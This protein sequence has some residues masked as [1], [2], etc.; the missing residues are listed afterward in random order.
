L[1]Y[2][3][4]R[5]WEEI[6]FHDPLADAEDDESGESFD[7]AFNAVAARWVDR[8]PSPADLEETVWPRELREERPVIQ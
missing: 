4:G 6:N 5:H 1:W 8:M 2:A 7:E 3:R